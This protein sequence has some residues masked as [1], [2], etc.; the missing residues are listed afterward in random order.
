MGRS[1]LKAKQTAAAAVF[2][3]LMVVLVYLSAVFPTMSMSIIAI[4]GVI[5]A[6]LVSE[7]GI[8]TAAMAYVSASVLMFVLVP[9]KSNALLFAIVF[10]I[11]PVLQNLIERVKHKWLTWVIKIAVANFI[12][13]ITWILFKTLFF[14]DAEGLI[15][16][17]WL[18]LIAANVIFI[19]YDICL[20]KLVFFYKIRIAKR[21]R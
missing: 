17:T 15:G 4:A 2:T 6:V 11:Y 18:L 5:S 9:D 1:G 7:Y 19:M 8:T 13:L 3:A 16:L 21:I 14:T 10:G 20:K 12:F